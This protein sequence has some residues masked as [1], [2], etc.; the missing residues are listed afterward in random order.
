MSDPTLRDLLPPKVRAWTYI[1]LS[2]VDA[3]YVPAEALYD[4]PTWVPI[5]FA[6]ANAAGFQL[7]RSNTPAPEPPPAL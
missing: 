6:V 3:A 1:V 5:V 2:L 4:L 7:A